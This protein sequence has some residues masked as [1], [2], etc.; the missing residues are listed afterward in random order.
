MR[1]EAKNVSEPEADVEHEIKQHLRGRHRGE[2]KKKW[3]SA[4]VL[5][6]L[7]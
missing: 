5:H 2:L 4:L 7:G 6:K 3:K 1:M